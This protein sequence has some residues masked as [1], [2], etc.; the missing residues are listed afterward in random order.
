[1]HTNGQEQLTNFGSQKGL[2][3]FNSNPATN[4]KFRE[5]FGMSKFDKQALLSGLLF[6]SYTCSQF[7]S[8]Q[9]VHD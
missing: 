2:T 8:L 3:F 6:L 5:F 4:L 9:L 1:M 7:E